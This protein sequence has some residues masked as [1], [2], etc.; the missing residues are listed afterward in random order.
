MPL[1]FSKENTCTHDLFFKEHSS[2]IPDP[3]KPKGRTLFVA[4]IPPYVSTEDIKYVFE[5]AGQVKNVIVEGDKDCFKF[6]YII[7]TKSSSV[8]NVFKLTYLRPLSSETRTVKTGIAKWIEEYN[9]S[10]ENEEEL[11]AKVRFT[12]QKYDNNQ[13][14]EKE[15]NDDSGWTVVTKKSRT[16]GL[17]RTESVRKKLSEKNAKKKKQLQNFYTFQIRESK[18][19]HIAN[20]RKK[21]EEDKKRVQ[22]MKQAR[23][24]KPF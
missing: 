21:Y 15:V 8:Q 24:F 5:I 23:K 2:K 4:N 1:S 10:I 6:A 19:N 20:L 13:Y 3:D 22:A 9:N 11:K 16:P 18:K 7:Y 14:R 12:I 17:S